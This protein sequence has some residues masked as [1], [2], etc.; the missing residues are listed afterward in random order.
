MPGVK[1]F[2]N[3]SLFELL[4]IIGFLF[5]LMIYIQRID[6]RQKELAARI[7][8]LSL[9]FQKIE[10]DI[11]AVQSS[12]LILARNDSDVVETISKIRDRREVIY[13]HIIENGPTIREILRGIELP[14]LEDDP[15]FW[16]GDGSIADKMKLAKSISEVRGEIEEE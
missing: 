10:N 3:A 12:I 15:A 14:N 13:R 5:T 9:T 8:R 6:R 16:K 11:D 2:E 4:A 7:G 1:M